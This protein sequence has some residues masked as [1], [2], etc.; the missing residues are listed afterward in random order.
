MQAEVFEQLKL[1]GD[2]AVKATRESHEFVFKTRTVECDNALKFTLD[3]GTEPG[4]W[5]VIGM[6]NTAFC[7]GYLPRR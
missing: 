3:Y 1:I 2:K 6:N 4:P 7:I 5:A